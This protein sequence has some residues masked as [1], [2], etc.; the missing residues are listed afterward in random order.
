MRLPSLVLIVLLVSTAAQSQTLLQPRE[1]IG[2][3]RLFNNDAIGDGHDRWRTGSFVYSLVRAPQPYDGTLPKFGDLVE[4]RLRSEII[5]PDSVTRGRPFVGLLSAGAHTHFG[6]GGAQARVGTDLVVVGPQT[7]LDDFQTFYHDLFGLQDPLTS[8][9]LD[10]DVFLDVSAE[11]RQDFVLGPV[12]SVQPFAEARL[13]SEDLARVGAD[14]IFG[15]VVQEDLSMRD[16]TTGQLYPGVGG[17]TTGLGFVLGADVAAV[18]DSSFLPE[19]FGFQASDIRRRARAGVTVQ[20]NPFLSMFYGATYLSPE[21]E[22]Q[23]EG[24]VSGSLRIEFNF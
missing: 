1:P 9:Q 4:Y 19:R 23:P 5:A 15:R 16:V 10:D 7:G 11:V 24:Q 13:G 3:G 2:S 12:A 20:P 17:D 8:P 18:S 21:F 14:L 6:L 22:T